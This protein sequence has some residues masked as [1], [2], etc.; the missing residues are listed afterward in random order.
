M[1][2]ASYSFGK[3]KRKRGREV[4]LWL[5]LNPTQRGGQGGEVVGRRRPSYGWLALLGLGLVLGSAQRPG[6]GRAGA[7]VHGGVCGPL[8]G[9]LWT[10]STLSLLLFGPRRTGCSQEALSPSSPLLP[11]SHDADGQRHALAA[12]RCLF[13]PLFFHSK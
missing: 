3:K 6:S 7:R 9:S 13:P 1:I 5:G 11:L 10:W 2:Y 8:A 4:T 12:L